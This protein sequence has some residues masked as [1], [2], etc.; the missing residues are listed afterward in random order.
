MAVCN[1]SSLSPV[2]KAVDSYWLCWNSL[3]HI[4]G[5]VD[6]NQELNINKIVHPQAA[7]LLIPS[8]ND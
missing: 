4:L 5:S 2:L 6:D 7:F 1:K 3:L 8:S